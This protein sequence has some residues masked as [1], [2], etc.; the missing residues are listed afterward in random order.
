MFSTALIALLT[1]SA[2]A[3]SLLAGADCPL[4]GPEFPAPRNLSKSPAISTAITFF[5]SL[6]NTTAGATSNSSAY[7]AS[8]FSLYDSNPLFQVHYTP[9]APVGVARV[10]SNSIY[11]IGSV[12]KVLTVWTFLIEAGDAYFGDSITKYV[13]EL[14]NTSKLAAGTVYDDIDNVRWEDVTLGDLAGQTAGIAR[15][16]RTDRYTNRGISANSEQ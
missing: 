3:Q 8:F 2:A 12:T 11:R 4:F 14:K 1:A 15:D 5:N 9:P 16:G 13:P 10:D 6:L 7:S